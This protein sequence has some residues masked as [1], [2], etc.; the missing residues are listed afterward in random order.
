M[1]WRILFFLCPN[2]TPRSTPL[3][4]H[5]TSNGVFQSGEIM[6]GADTHFS[7]SSLN[8][9]RQDSSK[10]IYNLSPTVCTMDVQ[11][12]KSLWWISGKT[13]HAQ[14]IFSHLSQRSV[15]EVSLLLD[16]STKLQSSHLLRTYD[17]LV[18]HRSNESPT[19]EK[20]SIKNSIIFST[21]S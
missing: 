17:K 19:T 8:A 13:L 12:L 3:A 9:L 21:M 18:K 11:S 5:I 4:S 14:E 20:S 1:G 10:Q 7:F 6:I 16:F 2:T 15:G